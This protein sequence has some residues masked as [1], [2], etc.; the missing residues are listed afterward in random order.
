MR[1]STDHGRTRRVLVLSILA[2]SPGCSWAFVH[3]PPGPPEGAPGDQRVPASAAGCTTSNAA[4]IVDTVLAV[5]LVALGGLAVAGAIEEGK[6]STGTSTFKFDF[7]S[8]GEWLAIA[9]GAFALGGLAIASAATGYGRTADCRRLQEA[10]AGPP[11]PGE[12]YLLDVNAIAQAR[13]HP[14]AWAVAP[15]H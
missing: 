14:D 15:A 7:G 6:G 2:S 5:P 12:R 9:A 11:H 1:P 4:P 3:G 10:Q 8:T 13:A